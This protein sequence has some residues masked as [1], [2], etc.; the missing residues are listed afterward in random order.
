MDL[1]ALLIKQK[2]AIREYL[3]CSDAQWEAMVQLIRQ[4]DRENRRYDSEKPWT[5]LLACGYALAGEAGVKRLAFLLTG[6][7][8]PAL[9]NPKIWLEAM[10]TEPRIGEGKTH[11]DL[12]LG[13]IKRREGTDSGIELD[14]DQPVWICFCEMK[15][16][17]DAQGSVTHDPNRNQ[18]ARVIENALCFQKLGHY[19]EDV[20]VTVVTPHG[21]KSVRTLLRNKFEE[22]GDRDRLLGDLQACALEK[23]AATQVYPENMAERVREHLQVRWVS[24]DDLVRGLPKSELSPYLQEAWK[25]ERPRTPAVSK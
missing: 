20:F 14:G 21:F 18:L 7:A 1:A 25:K 17:S 16:D 5:F 3:Y 10:P 23:N 2:S 13:A 6:P 9:A 15:W 4:R 8:R 22:Y 19:A 12:A 24:H 11:V